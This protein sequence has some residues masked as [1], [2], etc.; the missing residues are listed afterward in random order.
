MKT[1]RSITLFSLIISTIYSCNM[2]N[3]SAEQLDLKRCRDLIEVKQDDPFFLELTDFLKSLL[4]CSKISIYYNKLTKEEDEELLAS[5]SEHINYYTQAF[6]DSSLLTKDY[7]KMDLGE[8][9]KPCKYKRGVCNFYTQY[10]YHS[11]DMDVLYIR[12][13]QEGEL[14]RFDLLVKRNEDGE[15]EVL[16]VG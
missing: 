13:F 5:F 2:N 9:K 10:I 8:Y 14:E 11:K 4:S 3:N 15:F 7:V 1:L 6:S 16:A 12:L